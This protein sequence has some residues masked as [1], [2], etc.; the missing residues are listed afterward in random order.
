[1][2]VERFGV[3]RESFTFNRRVRGRTA[4]V[5]IRPL[6]CHLVC[7]I[8]VERCYPVLPDEGS[9]RN[10]VKP[11]VNCPANPLRAV[12][13]SGRVLAEAVRL[14]HNHLQLF[15]CELCIPRRR[16]RGSKPSRSHHLDDVNTRLVVRAHHMPDLGYRVNFPTGRP[17]VSPRGGDL[18]SRS[19]NPRP[20]RKALEDGLTR[21]HIR[22]VAR[23]KGLNGRHP[24]RRQ[25]AS[26]LDRTEGMPCTVMHFR[27]RHPRFGVVRKS[28][29]VSV[30]FH[31]ARHDGR[32]RMMFNRQRRI[33][34]G[35]LPSRACPGNLAVDNNHGA[36]IHNAAPPTREHLARR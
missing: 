18:R 29:Q 21:R 17:R 20:F 22:E 26:N 28:S 16:T 7:N 34:V 25:L 8:R 2:V 32:T 9:V 6:P 19:N 4:Q 23:P 24:H 11:G 1:M 10:V 5:H 27:I 15:R 35:H 30:G 3:G 14:L 36:V 33:L 31:H 12:S 13:V